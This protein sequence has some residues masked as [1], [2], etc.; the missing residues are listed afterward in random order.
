LQLLSL[1]ENEAIHL[2]K[3]LDKMLGRSFLRG[4]LELE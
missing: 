4:L 2:G 3:M 1:F